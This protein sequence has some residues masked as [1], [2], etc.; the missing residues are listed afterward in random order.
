MSEIVFFSWIGLILNLDY[1]FIRSYCQ[2]SA[3]SEMKPLHGVEF[4]WKPIGFVEVLELHVISLYDLL[5]GH[6][7]DELVIMDKLG[8]VEALEDIEA[9]KSLSPN[10]RLLLLH[11]YT[12]RL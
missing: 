3:A 8:F 10:L 2:E 9:V 12:D 6:M 11:D 5:L 1:P 7:Y 4:R